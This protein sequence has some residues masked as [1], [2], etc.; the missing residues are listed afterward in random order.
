MLLTLLNS[1]SRLEGIYPINTVRSSRYGPASDW[2]IRAGPVF[3]VPSALFN[4]NHCYLSYLMA[5]RVRIINYFFIQWK[6]YFG[7]DLGTH[8]NYYF[9]TG[10]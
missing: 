1:R 6:R 10:K 7:T 5:L 2:Y 8:I 4:R 3:P 9:I